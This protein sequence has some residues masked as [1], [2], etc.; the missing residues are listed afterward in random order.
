LFEV[1]LD[2][3]NDD[4]TRVAEEDDLEDKEAV[5]E[6]DLALDDDSELAFSAEV[7]QDDFLGDDVEVESWSDDPVRMYLTQM[8]EIPLL[9]RAEEIHLARKIEITRAKFRRKL[10]EC[11]YILR[12]AVKVLRRVHEGELPF[13]RTVQVSVTDKLEKDQILGRLP[14]NLKT[15]EALMKRNQRD[16]RIA[17]SKSR[18]VTLRRTAWKRLGR[19][20]AKCVRLVEELG[21]RTQRIESRIEVLAQFSHRA[22]ELKATIEAHKKS[23]GPVAERRPLVDELR[24]TLVSLQETPTSLRNRVRLV[25]EVYKEYQQAKRGLSEGNLRLVVSIAKKYRNR[26]LSFLD[27]IQE[28][29]AGLMRAVDKFEYRRGFKFCTYATWWI[30]QAITRA[31]ADQSRTI[32]IPVHM[33]ETMSRVRNVARELLQEFGREP[34]L[35]ETATRA[36]T[37]VD[38]ARRV[39]AMSRYPISLDRPVGNSEDSQ[40]GDLL[41]DSAARSPAIGANQDMLRN[42]INKVLKTL[43]YREREIIKLRYGLGDGY[44][45]TLEE[46]GHIFKVTRERIR[47]IEAKAVRKLQQPSR[48]QELVGFLD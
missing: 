22:D 6:D 5:D 9:T 46:V 38:E 26:G 35:E 4:V 45:Y 34:T 36:Q 21:L 15:L 24:R 27:L 23:R 40:F 12:D 16:F 13:D 1:L 19:T 7:D 29:N 20:R 42:R 17:T 10:L 8:G 48:S 41:P 11:D 28:G 14:L 30:R 32:R 43:S 44:S 2:D 18:R 25:R 39:L 3:M 37:T 33:V 31:V 47:Q